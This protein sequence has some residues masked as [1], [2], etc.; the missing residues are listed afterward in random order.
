M[1]GFD[2]VGSTLK[3]LNG[4]PYIHCTGRIKV[5]LATGADRDAE[6]SEFV[7]HMADLNAF[8]AEDA[9]KRLA[10]DGIFSACML[11]FHIFFK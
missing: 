9:L 11:V 8:T 6:T 7:N 3:M 5:S 1:C 10:L 2:F 4:I